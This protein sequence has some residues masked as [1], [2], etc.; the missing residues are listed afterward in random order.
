MDK[1]HFKG[2]HRKFVPNRI[3]G[4]DNFGAWYLPVTAHYFDG[5]TTIFYKPVPPEQLPPDAA[6][7]SKQ[8]VAQQQRKAHQWPGNALSLPTRLPSSSPASLTSPPSGNLPTRSAAKGLTKS[9]RA[10][11]KRFRQRGLR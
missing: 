5:V 10:L 3:V 8:I 11:L 9:Q 1:L 7:Y 4:P 2:D 6:L